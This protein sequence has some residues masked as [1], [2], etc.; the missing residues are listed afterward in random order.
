[1]GN[2]PRKIFWNVEAINLEYEINVYITHVVLCYQ[3]GYWKLDHL[4]SSLYYKFNGSIKL[5]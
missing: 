2:S 1:M 3:T 5:F 4:N